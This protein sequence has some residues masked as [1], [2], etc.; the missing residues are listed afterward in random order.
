[1]SPSSPPTTSVSTLKES[2]EVSSFKG[3]LERAQSILQ[4]WTSTHSPPRPIALSS[5]LN[6]A[7]SYGHVSVVRLLLEHGALIDTAT[8]VLATTHDN[9]NSLAIFETLL[10][11][12]WSVQSTTKHGTMAMW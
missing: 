11:H 3:D 1:M 12:G 5:A 2:L 8:A 9:P 10:E 6:T 7:A 4:T